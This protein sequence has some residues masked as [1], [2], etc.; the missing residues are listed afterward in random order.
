MKEEDCAKTVVIK[1]DGRTVA[2]LREKIEQ[3]ILKAEASLNETISEKRKKKLAALT[4]DVLK[5][6][7]NRFS[8]TVQ[9]YEIQNII[10]HL[11]IESGESQLAQSYITYRVDR[12]LRR[13]NQMDFQWALSRLTNKDASVVNENANKDSK[14]FNTQ[15]DLTAGTVAKIIG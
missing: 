4:Q 13:K 2:F 15:R 11:L 12:D 14:V 3:A 6:I 7:S 8:E 1:R 10:E 9:I 5:E